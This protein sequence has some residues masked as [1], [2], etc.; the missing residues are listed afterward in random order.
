MGFPK[1][2]KHLKRET[3]GRP[4]TPGKSLLTSFVASA[5]L[6]ATAALAQPAKSGSNES[7]PGRTAGTR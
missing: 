3:R 2:D 1:L 6:I 5:A 4:M 7:A